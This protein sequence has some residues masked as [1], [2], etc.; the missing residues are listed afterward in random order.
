MSIK[1]KESKEEQ[2]L[3]IEEII[4]KCWEADAD[5]FL[6][7]EVCGEV[8]THIIIDGHKSHYKD[9]RLSQREL[10]YILCAMFDD[11]NREKPFNINLFQSVDSTI[12]KSLLSGNNNVNY[13]LRTIP[14]E[15]GFTAI[16]RFE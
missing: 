7:E 9:D 16:M 4:M 13:D 14:N 1:A 11:V 6:I 12:P 10:H 15:D 2:A 5:G 3:I 8:L